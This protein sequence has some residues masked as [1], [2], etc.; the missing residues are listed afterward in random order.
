MGCFGSWAGW[1]VVAVAA[2]I[3]AIAFAEPEEKVQIVG[4]AS[5]TLRP[6]GEP[7]QTRTVRLPFRWDT[8]FPGL[9]GRA[10]Y[11]IALPERPE[12]GDL[13]SIL[14]ETPGNQ[15]EILLNGTPVAS[16]GILGDPRHDAAKSTYLIPL[17]AKSIPANY[18]LEVIT[19]VQRQRAGGL[20]LV[21][22][23]PTEQLTRLHGTHQWIITASTIYAV[24]F[25]LMG[26]LAAGLW[27]KQRDPLYGCFSLA[28]L[29][30]IP[31]NIDR[32]WL[33]VPVSWP[34]WGGIIA[35]TYAIHI[36]LIARF[37]L[38]AADKHPKIV[39]RFLYGGLA[40]VIVLAIASFSLAI[41]MLWTIAQFILI[42]N[43]S[44]CVPYIV[45]EAIDKK[46]PLAW[47]LMVVGVITILAG[48]RGVLMVRLNLFGGSWITI[49]PH[50]MFI[51]VAI[52]GLMV[53][54]RYSRL[55]K[56]Y[57]G[58]N[59]SLKDQVAAREAELRKTFELVERQRQD[60]AVLLER[61]RMM[62]EIH[63]GV[64]SQLVGLLNVVSQEDP[65]K[66]SME[67][68]VK[69]ALDEMRMAV[70]SLQDT[71]SDLGTVLATLRYR[72]QA[73]LD[74]A[75]LRM[76]WDVESLPS[77]AVSSQ[78]SLQIQRIL[79]EAFTN[80]IKH[81][82]ATT[83]K[84]AARAPVN[85][86]VCIEISDDGIGRAQ[87]PS[88]GVAGRGV[89]N[90]KWR[91]RSIGAELTIGPGATQGTAVALIL[92]RSGSPDTAPRNA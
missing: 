1:I 76:Q 74:A 4:T 15:A 40:L 41:P 26:L 72:V 71:H 82:K 30:G 57:K 28:A 16:L 13:L 53:V 86:K 60:Q 49:T 12:G 20:G 37:V 89:E 24:G 31:R 18:V 10:T 6:D 42:A 63:D 75:G 70:D 66:M 56:D 80:I 83:I 35:V 90:M 19:T 77:V 64:G 51:F 69:V 22:I 88:S 92:D 44:A 81:A 7:P 55:V 32:G 36:A 11:L 59:E 17:R 68:H 79:L 84:V 78:E 2:L 5:A 73:R 29:S 9:N 58:L 65:D 14:V 25:L 61:Q 48:I 54:D 45:R 91:A 85:G 23:G 87:A 47:A 43:N 52:L 38:F 33:D 27:V 67:E 21:R 62:R 50:S 39:L 3:G 34:L 46:S 8:T